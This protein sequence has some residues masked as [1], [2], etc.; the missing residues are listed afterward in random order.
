MR[1]SVSI[2][3]LGRERGGRRE[4]GGRETYL[5]TVSRSGLTKLARLPHDLVVLGVRGLI[6]RTLTL[7]GRVGGSAEVLEA[8]LLGVP[9]EALV[10]AGLSGSFS[11]AVVASGGSQ[12]H[13]GQGE[14]GEERFGLHGD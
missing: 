10:G 13:G 4:K 5:L 11:V 14:D 2:L 1:E 6:T 12:R 9:V 8:G 3:T 7:A